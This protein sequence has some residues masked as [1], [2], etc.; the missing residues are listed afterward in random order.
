M[1]EVQS[2]I[3]LDCIRHPLEATDT[4]GAITELIQLL[5]EQGLVADAEDTAD[6]VWARE[7]QRSTGIG[8]GLAVPHGRCPALRKVVAAVGWTPTPIDFKAADG[9]PVQLIVL[10]VSPPEDTSAHV[11]ALGAIS[12]VL[13]QAAIREAAMESTSAESLHSILCQTD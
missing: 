4:R 2:L 7:L 10:I 11:Q 13:S 6:A 1:I 8:E 3:Q 5:H 12:R 9:K